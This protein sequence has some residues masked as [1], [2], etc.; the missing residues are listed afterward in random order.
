MRRTAIVLAAVGL[1]GLTG[2]ANLD[3]TEQRILTGSTIGAGTG[4]VIGAFTG[5][6][7]VGSG[8]AIGAAIGA[9]VG[10]VTDQAVEP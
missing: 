9:G 7:S 10:Y 2:C 3:S 5:G 6:L 8:A 4:A 1:M